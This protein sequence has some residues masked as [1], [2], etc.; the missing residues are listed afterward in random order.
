MGTPLLLQLPGGLPRGRFATGASLLTLTPE[1]D[2]SP[3]SPRGRHDRL[4]LRI[5]RSREGDRAAF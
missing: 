5:S 1:D 2:A 3:K 4:D